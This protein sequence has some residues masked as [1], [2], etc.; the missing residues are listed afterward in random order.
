MWSM[1]GKEGTWIPWEE[2]PNEEM[3]EA[4][5]GLGLKTQFE[6]FGHCIWGLENPGELWFIVKQ[7][8]LMHQVGIRMMRMGTNGE[9]HEAETHGEVSL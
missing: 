7:K 2:S 8:G 9:K 1:G 3:M 4:G 6:K 5:F